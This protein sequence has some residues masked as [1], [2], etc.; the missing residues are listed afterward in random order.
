MKLIFEERELVFKEDSIIMKD[1]WLPETE[2]EVMM[3]WEDSL[4]KRHAEVVCSNGGDILEIGFGMGISANYIQGLNPTSHTIVENH[5][6][7]IEKL[8]EWASDKPNVKIVNGSWYNK[9]DEFGIYDGIFYDAFGDRDWKKFKDV[10]PNITKEGTIFTFWNNCDDRT[11]NHDLDEEYGVVY[12]EIEIDPPQNS[13]FN[14]KKYY[15]PK[16]II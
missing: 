1:S 5:P 9:Q 10:L 6:Q 16:V 4:M 13:Y 15:L 8:E 11:N 3:S 14:H 2:T 12:E 7:I